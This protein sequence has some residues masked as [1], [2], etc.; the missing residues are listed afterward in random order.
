[1]AFLALLFNALWVASLALVIA[2]I[3]LY[4]RSYGKTRAPLSAGPLLF[5]FAF[6]ALL[7]VMGYHNLLLYGMEGGLPEAVVESF[8]AQHVMALLPA[9]G[10]LAVLLYMAA[11]K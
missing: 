6:L 1:M 4:V 10:A 5:A 3:A 8:L 9:I 2:L 11:V 7:L